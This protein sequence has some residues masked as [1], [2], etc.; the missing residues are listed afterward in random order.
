MR[1]GDSTAAT[2]D[3]PASAVGAPA[4]EAQPRTPILGEGIG[5]SIVKQ[6][7]ELLNASI[8]L[9]T[10]PGQGTKFRV[11]FPVRYNQELV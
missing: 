7:C 5:L 11:V 3:Q 4:V 8:E 6:L 9:T 2:P 1:S 10:E